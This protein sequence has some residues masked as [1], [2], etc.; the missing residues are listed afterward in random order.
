VRL[1]FWRREART[2]RPTPIDVNEV[3]E[4]LHVIRT[5]LSRRVKEMDRRYKELFENVV[6][7]HMEKDQEKAAIYAQ[8]L[9]ELKKILRRLTHASL[10]LEGTAYRL[11]AVKDLSD[12]SGIIVPLRSV[13][14][15]A[16][17]ELTEVAPATCNKLRE[18]IDS[19]E[20]FSVQVG[21]IPENGGLNSELSDEAKK[22]LDEASAIASQKGRKAVEEE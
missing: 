9:S 6:K 17:N 1:R 2:P 22:I 11:E 18:L 15:A 4:R 13:L 8:E 10:L 19:I 14:A 16:S 20:E 3:I 12:A 21:Y 7:A 5:R